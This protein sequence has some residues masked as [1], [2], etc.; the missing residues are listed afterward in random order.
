MTGSPIS[1]IPLPTLKIGHSIEFISIVVIIVATCASMLAD[2]PFS[3][4][5]QLELKE[6]SFQGGV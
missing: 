3:K 4:G 6:I 5:E 2:Y 1:A